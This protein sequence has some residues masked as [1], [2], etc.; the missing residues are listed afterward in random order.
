MIILEKPPENAIQFSHP[1]L[2]TS[3]AWIIEN[4]VKDFEAQ[5]RKYCVTRE[6]RKLK[7]QPMDYL[8]LWKV[9]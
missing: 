5:G 9:L 6:Q 2:T 8:I 4:M 7:G 1:C 3:E